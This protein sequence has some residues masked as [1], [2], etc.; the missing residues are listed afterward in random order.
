[1]PPVSDNVMCNVAD[2]CDQLGKKFQE[3]LQRAN[4]VGL[5]LSVYNSAI[6]FGGLGTWHFP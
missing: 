3:F 6:G 4:H 5:Y 2:I 1:V